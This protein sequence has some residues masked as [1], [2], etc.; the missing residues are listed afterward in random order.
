MA[1]ISLMEKLIFSLE[2]KEHVIGLFLDFSKPFDTIDHDIMLCKLSYYGIR[3]NALKWFESYLRWRQQY[4]TYN[5]VSS[6]K[7]TIS[8][9][10]SQGSILGPLLFLIYINDLSVACKIFLSN[11]FRW[12]HKPVF[13]WNQYGYHGKGN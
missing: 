3:G 11:F 13:L 7:N 5:G 6:M 12:W 1:L 8:Y 2:N 9:G 10:V 4:V